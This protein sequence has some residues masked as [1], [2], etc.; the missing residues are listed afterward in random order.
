MLRDGPGWLLF[1][2]REPIKMDWFRQNLIVRAHNT[3][4]VCFEDPAVNVA[5][6]LS[7][8]NS[9]CGFLNNT[10]LADL[11][12]INHNIITGISGPRYTA[13][14]IYILKWKAN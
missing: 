8:I 1:F 7:F 5:S 13:F 2:M 14:L 9:F 4:F 11:H 3:I 6:R 10:S 12:K